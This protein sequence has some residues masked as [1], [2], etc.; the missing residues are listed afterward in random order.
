MSDK[1]TARDTKKRGG[2]VKWFRE[3][4]SELKKIVW[5][6]WQQVANN[7]KI[8][9]TIVAIIG[10]FIWI[11]DVAFQAGTTYLIMLGS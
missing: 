4:K 1:K 6:T 3:M 10:I 7:T 9:L 8:V 2:I 5:P 11:A